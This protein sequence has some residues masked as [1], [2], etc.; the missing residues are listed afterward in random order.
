LAQHDFARHLSD[1][2]LVITG[3]GR[4]DAQSLH[5]KTP[6]AVARRA[7]S[8]GVPTVAL[9]GSLGSDV[10][11]AMLQAAGIQAVLS[12]TPDSMALAEAL[13]RADDLLAAAA[14]RLGYSL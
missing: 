6:I 5:G 2:K 3:E 12:I 1:A 14:E 7:Q 13:R 10:D 8:A 9:V 4:L 11:A